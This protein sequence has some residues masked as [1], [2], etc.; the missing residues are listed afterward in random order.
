MLPTAPNSGLIGSTQLMR[1]E[2]TS[3][4]ARRSGPLLVRA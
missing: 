4:P 2:L 3:L 1:F